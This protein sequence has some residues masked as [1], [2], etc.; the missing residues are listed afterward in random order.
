MHEEVGSTSVAGVPKTFLDATGYRAALIQAGQVRGARNVCKLLADAQAR[1][2]PAAAETLAAIPSRG[3][4]SREPDTL[5]R[6]SVRVYACLIS[7]T[8]PLS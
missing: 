1:Q 8:G 3:A 2:R 4:K 7:I 6:F 5:P